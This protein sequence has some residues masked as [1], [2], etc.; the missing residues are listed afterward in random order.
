M[1]KN[2]FPLDHVGSSPYD[3]SAREALR[4]STSATGWAAF[5]FSLATL[6][7]VGL[8]VYEKL[9]GHSWMWGPS[10]VCV[11]GLLINI[12]GYR[13]LVVREANLALLGQEPNQLKDPTP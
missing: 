11:G 1:A 6:A 8:T 3:V 2:D 7:T 4:Q 9:R 10:A 13:R 12:F 5:V